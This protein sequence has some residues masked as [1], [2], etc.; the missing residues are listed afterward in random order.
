ME[1]WS[2]WAKCPG[3]LYKFP[4]GTT[5]RYARAFA[6]VSLL[7]AVGAQAMQAPQ[8]PAAKKP[9]VGTAA[10]AEEPLDIWQIDLNPSGTGFALTTPV[11]QGDVYVFKVWPDRAT[12]RLNKSRVKKMVRRTRDINSE[13]IYQID[14][15]P[16]GQV[17]SRE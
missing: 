12:V 4:G 3:K 14:L 6:L 1:P 5:M 16:T 15:N 11:L 9:A 2:Y 10:A 13:V 17:F 7:F 8:N